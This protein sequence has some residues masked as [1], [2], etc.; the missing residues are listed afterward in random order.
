MPKEKARPGE[1]LIARN[2]RA[3]FN[4]DLGDRFEAGIVLK[5][6]EVKMLRAGKADLTDSFC[7]VSRGEVFLQ[8][9]SIAEMAGAAFGHLPK[10][11]R[12]LLLHRREI[13][14]IELSIAREGMTAV[15]TRLY[16]K[17][18]LAKV[19]IALAR[20]KKIH[21]KREAIRA[22]DAEREARAVVVY[23]QRRYGRA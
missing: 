13:Q 3:S 4:Y 11:A 6:S 21:D 20:G 10:G 12:K 1:T 2:K 14:R 8:G 19:E 17:S 15:A 9:V 7:T 18:G 23:G 22:Q 16:F 5:G